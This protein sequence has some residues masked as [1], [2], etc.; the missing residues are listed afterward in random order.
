MEDAEN[1]RIFKLV[2]Q[3]IQGI[4]GKGFFDL[5]GIKIKGMY[6]CHNVQQGD[7]LGL[8]RGLRFNINAQL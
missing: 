6:E 3:T 7:E 2:D 5:G 1:S 8:T 4:S